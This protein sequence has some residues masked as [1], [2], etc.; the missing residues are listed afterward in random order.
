MTITEV[1]LRVDFIGGWLDCPGLTK[2]VGH[3]INCAITPK[4][5]LDSWPY[6]FG[7]GLG[8]SA[9]N[10]ILRDNNPFIEESK[11]A[12]WQ[13]PAVILETGLCVWSGGPFPI[14][15]FKVNPAFLEGKMALMWTGNAHVTKDLK[16]I[17][18]DYRD[19]AWRSNLAYTWLLVRAKAQ[20][21]AYTTGQPPLSMY[22]TICE[23]VKAAYE[24]QLKEGMKPLR[25][26]YGESAK[27]YCGSGHG[28]YALYLFETTEHRND[29]VTTFKSR[30]IDTIAIE[31]Y[32]YDSFSHWVTT[33]AA[34]E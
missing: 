19:L 22:P 12:G 11:T 7:G 31:P 29:F 18:R 33:G 28:G 4:V 34:E 10:A 23:I 13:D 17:S 2:V 21:D 8:G 30:G 32:M 15:T 9:A 26:S 24:L 25:D 16:N 14:L 6:Q 3:V 27:K 1:P 5:S 20:S